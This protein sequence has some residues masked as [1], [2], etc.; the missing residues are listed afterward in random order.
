[1]KAGP[2]VDLKVAQDCLGEGRERFVVVRLHPALDGYDEGE[3]RRFRAQPGGQ[4]VRAAFA[5]GGTDR[6]GD[7]GVLEQSPLLQVAVGRDHPPALD[8][9]GPSLRGH[10]R[11]G[12]R[13][14]RPQALR[15]RR[16]RSGSADA[17]G[18]Q[19]GQYILAAEQDLTLV[20][21]GMPG[22]PS[23]L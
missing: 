2:A 7:P 18:E 23:V 9:L 12:G 14:R 11:V 5:Q 20:G 13:E 8:G 21:E 1:M 4:L 22:R 3:H 6:R 16:V 19:A 10:D 15:E 17:V